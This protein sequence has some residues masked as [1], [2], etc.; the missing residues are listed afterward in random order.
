MIATA[1]VIWLI[2]L[3][4]SAG[5]CFRLAR[6]PTISSRHI[7]TA[8]TDDTEGNQR[9]IQQKLAHWTHLKK[10]GLLTR[11]FD[12]DEDVEELDELVAERFTACPPIGHNVE[13]IEHTVCSAHLFG[14]KKKLAKLAARFV[15][16]GDG[17]T[18]RHVKGLYSLLQSL[19]TQEPSTLDTVESVMLDIARM[20]PPAF[21]PT[22]PAQRSAER[23][24]GGVRHQSTPATRPKTTI[25]AASVAG[26]GGDQGHLD[27]TVSRKQVAALV[28]YLTTCE[29]WS[30]DSRRIKD[31]AVKYVLQLFSQASSCE[32]AATVCRDLLLERGTVS[33]DAFLPGE[34]CAAIHR[35][36]SEHPPD[37]SLVT[38]LSNRLQRYNA[39][40]ARHPLYATNLILRTL[41]RYHQVGSIIIM[42]RAL[43][44]AAADTAAA[45]AATAG[46]KDGRTVGSLAPN[47]EGLEMLTNALVRSV[48]KGVKALSMSELPRGGADIPE[49]RPPLPLALTLVP[50]LFAG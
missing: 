38:D 30:V 23:V 16:D 7:A 27:C 24:A 9:M 39:Q 37:L 14:A 46:A 18:V 15:E 2:T 50:L 13:K 33:A 43:R 32:Q 47:S 21:G 12:S 49:V 17:D 19:A 11:S 4:Y 25:T 10:E 5:Y 40:I 26:H 8:Y 35:A 42:L 28:L 36:Y 29:K 45:S 1:L 20:K 6:L 41:A 31:F 34:L 48:G 44:V 22:G 3:T